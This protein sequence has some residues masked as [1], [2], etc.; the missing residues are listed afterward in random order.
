M[1][2][3]KFSEEELVARLKKELLNVS[4]NKTVLKK[5]EGTKGNGGLYSYLTKKERQTWI[6]KKLVTF[7]KNNQI[8]S[9]CKVTVMYTDD[10]DSKDYRENDEG[11]PEIWYKIKNI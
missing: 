9:D 2:N 4:K 6:D 11:D 10:W 7:K 5:F 3:F 1:K 8:S